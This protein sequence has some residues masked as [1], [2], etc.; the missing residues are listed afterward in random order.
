MMKTKFNLKA[1]R[2]FSLIEVM[3][4]TSIFMLIMGGVLTVFIMHLNASVT[5]QLIMNTSREAS[6]SLE[7]MVY[8]SPNRMGLRQFNFSDLVVTR[9]GAG[10]TVAGS[11]THFFQYR[12]LPGTIQDQGGR[13]LAN[14]IV[15]SAVQSVNTDGLALSVVVRKN[16]GARTSMT[17]NKTFVQFRN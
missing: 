2:G 6:F 10:W 5:G 14:N 11:P 3:M 4:S 15:T 7:R 13:V 12:T 9:N 8:G 1:L 16:H 17:T